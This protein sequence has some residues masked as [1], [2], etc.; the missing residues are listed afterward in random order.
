MKRLGCILLVLLAA[1]APVW[2]AAKKIT[3]QE[4]KDMLA[5]MQAAKKSDAEVADALKQVELSEELTR[6][7]MNNLA[8]SVPGQ[9]STEQIYVLEARSAMLPPPAADI[10]TDPAPDAAAQQAIVG[11]ATDY[12]GK[13]YGQLPSLAAVKT[14]LRFQDNV[15]ALSASS[16]MHGS[17]KEVDTGSGFSNAASFIHYIN[18]TETQVVS[19]HGTEKMPSDKDKTPWGANKMIALEMPDPSPVWVFSEAQANGGFKWERWETVYG[20]KV[21]V[22]SYGVPKKKSH[23]QLDVCCFPEEDQTGTARFSGQM[24]TGAPGG[25]ASAGG[26]AHGNFQTNTNYTKFFK[27]T[28]PYHGEFFVDPDNGTIVRMITEAELKSGDLVHQD[29][30]RIDY[31]PVKVGDQTVVVPVKSI[32]DTEVVP[33]GDS[34]QGGYSIRRTL[35]TAEYK[36]YQPAGGH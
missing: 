15:E 35:F 32:T 33:N 21:A 6:G 30:E 18:S 12:V 24:G 27:Q 4:L 9:L 34:G 11:K 29:D 7:T 23:L 19:D 14:T 36:S 3:V 26:G 16:G 25:S 20:K 8:G 5:Q 28:P 22:F 31:G 10:P 17:A 2:A 1:A 13:T